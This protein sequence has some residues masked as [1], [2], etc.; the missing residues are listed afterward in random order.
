MILTV[1]CEKKN[2][3]NYIIYLM[4]RMSYSK[5]NETLN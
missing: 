4:Q 3:Y 1:F 5:Q 2:N